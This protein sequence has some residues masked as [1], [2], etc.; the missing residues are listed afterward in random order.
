VAATDVCASAELDNV[1]AVIR[2]VDVFK[3]QLRL[4]QSYVR[5]AKK[6]N[7]AEAL[8]HASAT[9]AKS[10]AVQAY[11]EEDELCPDL[12]AIMQQY[13]DGDMRLIDT[14]LL[15]TIAC[16]LSDKGPWAI[17][18]NYLMYHERA[19]PI[20]SEPTLYLVVAACMLSSSAEAHTSV[21]AK[22]LSPTTGL[23]I[24]LS[25]SVCCSAGL[26]GATTVCVASATF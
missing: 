15:E 20:E 16:D 6:A 3:Q 24:T 2:M 10:V 12:G 23:P 1:H 25:S 8:R 4:L 22:S 11:P 17:V 18:Q 21:A 9:T 5:L 19:L 7:H 26:A 13:A 14:A